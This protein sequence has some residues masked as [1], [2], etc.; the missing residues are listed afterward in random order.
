MR[1]K[2]KFTDLKEP[3]EIENG[4]YDKEDSIG[5]WSLWQGNLEAQ[6]LVIGQDWGILSIN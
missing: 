3:S 4:K 5:P 2:F 6:I 1:K